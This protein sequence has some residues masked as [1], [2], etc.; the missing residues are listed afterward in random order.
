MHESVSAAVDLQ[1]GD[2]RVDGFAETSDPGVTVKRISHEVSFDDGETWIE[3]AFATEVT[4]APPPHDPKGP[5]GKA[6]IYTDVIGVKKTGLVRTK[7]T[8]D[9][10][11]DAAPAVE[12]PLAGAEPA[13]GV[14]I[15]P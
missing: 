4:P 15:D 11:L 12:K 3:I 10:P 13:S 14:R 2:R 5:I 6:G 7:V 1:T 8:H 9:V